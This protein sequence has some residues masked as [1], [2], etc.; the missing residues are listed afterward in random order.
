MKISTNNPATTF[1]NKALKVLSMTAMVLCAVSLTACS[2]DDDDDNQKQNGTDSARKIEVKASDIKGIPAGIEIAAV[3][4]VLYSDV[5]SGLEL[6]TSGW[7]NGFVI[8]LPETVSSANISPIKYYFMLDEAVTV[9]KNVNLA[10]VDLEVYDK[11]DNYLSDIAFG[12]VWNGTDM[13]WGM[14]V[15]TDDDCKVSGTQTEKDEDWSASYTFDLDLKK[16]WNRIYDI[17]KVID[18]NTEEVKLTTTAP[19]NIIWGWDTYL[20]Q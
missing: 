16:G 2:D 17:T 10:R 6:V 12:R 13:V 14:L 9:S 20:E 3:R 4:A 18:E 1:A 5:Q 7:D 11:E 8:E 15:Y 19:S